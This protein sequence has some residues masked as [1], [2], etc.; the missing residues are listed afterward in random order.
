M[1][2]YVVRIRSVMINPS[3]RTLSRRR[4]FNIRDSIVQ[5]SAG[6]DNMD[7]HD[8]TRPRQQVDWDER[9]QWQCGLE[10]SAEQST[11]VTE[12]QPARRGRPLRSDS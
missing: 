5:N 8:I 11:A 7:A 4:L 9:S 2:G 6:K 12:H 1:C 3:R 10:P